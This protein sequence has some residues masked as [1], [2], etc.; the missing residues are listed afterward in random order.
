MF[1]L[2][3]IDAHKGCFIATTGAV[4]IQLSIVEIKEG[5]NDRGAEIGFD[6]G[7]EILTFLIAVEHH[8]HQAIA[9]HGSAQLAGVIGLPA[10]D[11]AGVLGHALGGASVHVDA[12]DIKHF[13]LAV[14]VPNQNMIGIGLKIV[15]NAGAHLVKRRQIGNGCGACIDGQH[16]KIFIAAKVFL[17]QDNFVAF[18]E[19]ASHITFCL[20]RQLARIAGKLAVLQRLHKHVHALGATCGLH[21]AQRLAIIRQPVMRARR[22][23]EKIAQRVLL[24]DSPRLG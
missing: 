3:C 15:F 24:R 23:L 8:A 5:G 9:G 6:D 10:D 2:A 13:G 16:V 14:V 17:K 4:Q 22:V 11:I 19:I 7:S 12:V 21:E 1:W 18:E 20:L